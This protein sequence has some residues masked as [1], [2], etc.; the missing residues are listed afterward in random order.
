MKFRPPAEPVIGALGY[1]LGELL[2]VEGCG[3]SDGAV[4]NPFI[5]DRAGGRSVNPPV[6]LSA[7]GDVGRLEPDRRRTFFGFESV[8]WLGCP[9]GIEGF[10][11]AKDRVRLGAWTARRIFVVVG[12]Y[13][14]AGAPAQPAEPQAPSVM[15][16]P[17]GVLGHIVGTLLATEGVIAT[18]F[19][20]CDY[21]VEKVEGAALAQELVVDL[22]AAFD[23]VSNGA[24]LVDGYEVAWYGRAGWEFGF[25]ALRVRPKK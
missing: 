20:R 5:V 25:R 19:Q 1:P 7:R 3:G 24:A 10:V 4:R 14:V 12:P 15:A 16:E 13:R 9:P 17:S 6:I 21:L 18:G 11:P 23:E 22:G 8:E 2:A